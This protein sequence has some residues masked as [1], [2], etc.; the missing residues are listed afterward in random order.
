MQYS[1]GT[2]SSIMKF[3]KLNKKKYFGEDYAF[4]MFN[5]LYQY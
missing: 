2:E 1:I 4:Y 5:I 3:F